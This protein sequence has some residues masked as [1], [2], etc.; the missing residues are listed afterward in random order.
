M[1]SSL[2]QLVVQEIVLM[3]ENEPKHTSKL[4]QRYIKSKKE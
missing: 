1:Q 3:Q 2:K 4:N